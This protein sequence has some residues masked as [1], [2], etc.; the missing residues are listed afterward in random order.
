MVCI[1]EGRELD[2][3][4]LA[5][6]ET[7]LNYLL[8]NQPVS[9]LCVYDRERFRPDIIREVI[10]T[11]PLV[12]VGGTVC[13]NPYFVPPDDYLAPNWKARSSGC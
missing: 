4:Q 8:P 13:R 5:E 12:V 10:V 6:Y 9:A 7:K 3:E 11:H 2:V 1:A